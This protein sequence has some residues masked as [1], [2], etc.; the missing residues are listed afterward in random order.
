MTPAGCGELRALEWENGA[1]WSAKGPLARGN[2]ALSDERQRAVADAVALRDALHEQLLD[3]HVSAAAR[4]SG[5]LD[6]MEPAVQDADRLMAALNKWALKPMD[7]KRPP[8]LLEAVRALAASENALR[9]HLEKSRRRR[10]GKEQNGHTA[11]GKSTGRQRRP[12]A[13]GSGFG[14]GVAD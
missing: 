13:E 4:K 3:L 1:A 9:S 12:R 10:A 11:D 5:V 6:V 7:T 8:A 2:E 14:T